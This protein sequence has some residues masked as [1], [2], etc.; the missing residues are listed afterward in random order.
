L[1]MLKYILLNGEG[2]IFDRLVENIK[3]HSLTDLLIELM[4]IN[5]SFQSG[6]N[7]TTAGDDDDSSTEMNKPAPELTEEQQA[8]KVIL[9][10][11]KLMVVQ[12]LIR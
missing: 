9:D 8:M 5:V 7:N 10:S 12:K 11:K 3:Y 1:N 4:Q 6:M 2:L